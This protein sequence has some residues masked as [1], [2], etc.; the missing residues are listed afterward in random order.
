MGA[1]ES[2]MQVENFIYTE[3]AAATRNAM[4]QERFNS[5][6]DSIQ[7]PSWLQPIVNPL[8]LRH[9]NMCATQASRLAASAIGYDCD[10]WDDILGLDSGF[11]AE[12]GGGGGGGGDGGGGGGADDAA[13]QANFDAAWNAYM[14]RLNQP[15][16]ILRDAQGTP[17]EPEGPAIVQGFPRRIPKTPGVQ[18][19]ALPED[20]PQRVYNQDDSSEEPQLAIAQKEPGLPLMT[21]GIVATGGVL[22]FLWSTRER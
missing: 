20:E 14:D 12:V 3:A 17:L 5:F 13:F 22:I 21:I 16:P 10:R 1:A 6:V 15:P 18:T 9:D 7:P 2:V 11:D 4:G 19:K 8:N